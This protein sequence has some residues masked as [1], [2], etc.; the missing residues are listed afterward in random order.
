M[1]LILQEKITNLG[2]IGDQ[3][4]VK[5][6][7]ARNF[8]LP[9]GKAVPATPEYIAEFEKRRTELEKA[10]AKLLA[11]AKARANKLEGQTFKITANASEEGR[12][13]GSIGPREIAQAIIE[14][15]VEIEKRE[16]ALGQGPI[17]QIGEYEV[18]I[19]LHTDVSLNV[20]IEVAPENSNS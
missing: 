18:P 10:A 16:V 14:A 7:Y 11:K 1:K 17:R 13:F 9:L 3:V 6:G 20:K 15:G 5:P 2:N 4:V 12:L 8:L 19:R